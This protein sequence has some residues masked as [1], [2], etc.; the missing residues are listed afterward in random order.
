MGSPPAGILETTMQLATAFALLL[1]AAFPVA[2]GGAE[3]TARE[4][5]SGT[6]RSVESENGVALGK[7]LVPELPAHLLAP[8]QVEPI[9]AEQF[10]QVLAS[11]LGKVVVV[12]LWATW[13]LPCVQELPDFDLAQTRYRDR[14]LIVLAVSLDQA[15][16]LE[17]RV[18]PF[19]AERA[20][21]LVSYLQTEQDEFHFV[22]TFDPEWVGTLPSTY[23]FDRKGDLREAHHGR[24]LYRDLEAKALPLLDEKS[25]G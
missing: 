18:R 24:L 12:N 8:E 25:G 7:G 4:E 3:G 19:F 11:H 10:A 17:E 15:A 6:G 13:C 1:A 16:I 9:D 5:T 20:P 2:L 22:E 21:N 14:G 23:F